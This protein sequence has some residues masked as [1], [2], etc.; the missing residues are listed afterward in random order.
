MSR[1]LSTR[2]P[3]SRTWRLN[4]LLVGILLLFLIPIACSRIEL[5]VLEFNIIDAETGQPVPA[6]VSLWK[7][8]IPLIPENHPSYSRGSEHHFL[9][10]GPLRIETDGESSYRMT[11][12]RGLEYYSEELTWD[13]S[14]SGDG[15]I[16]LR[17]WVDMNREGWYSADM[18]VHRD[19]VD[20]PLIL[21][22][23]ELN[24]VPTITYHVWSEQVSTPFPSADEYPVQVDE[25]HFFTGNA[26]EVERIQGGPGAVI[27][28][29]ER[30]PIPFEGYEHYPPAAYFTQRV[31]DQGGFVEG[32][33]LFWLDTI[34][35]VALGEIDFIELNCNH[36]LPRDV[37]TDLAP[38]SHWPQEMGYLGDKGFALW[39][40]DSYYRLLNCGFD[41]PLSAGSANGVKATPV[42]YNRVY[43][44]L[45]EQ[46]LSYDNFLAAMKA[47]RSFSTNGP[48]ID[49]RVAEEFGPGRRMAVQPGQE[50]QISA[51]LK[52][53]VGLAEVEV[54]RNGEVIHSIAGG[55]GL[56]IQFQL[57]VTIQESS[58]IAVRAF[59]ESAETVRFAHTSPAWVSVD[60]RPVRV[61]SSARKLLGQVDELI[62]YTEA[63][64]TFADPAH[65][66]ETLELYRK[67]RAIYTRLAGPTQ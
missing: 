14:G 62:A 32:D 8:E 60:E 26:Q 21:L 44:Y 10:S 1:P 33:K 24:F 7:D 49:F 4:S 64:A 25:R 29:A 30:L 18:H 50:I 11:I 63:K 65:R 46:P 20:L 38:W 53:K 16:R 52:S 28:L 13:G 61:A 56:D 47:G 45:G 27:L 5:A 34:V 31:H 23:E 40:M 48:L 39:M 42:G 54:I 3:A 19:P 17:R 51:S 15:P 55:S 43:V 41:L 37:D 12:D 57:P 59:E 67:A 58:W 9:V 66:T 22:A 36:F 35:N 6:R 2:K